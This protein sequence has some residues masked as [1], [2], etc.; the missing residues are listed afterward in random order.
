MNDSCV[1]SKFEFGI[2]KQRLS[3][4]Y[5]LSFATL[6]YIDSIWV[7]IEDEE[8]QKGLGDAVPLLGYGNESTRDIVQ[9]IYDFRQECIGKSIKVSFQKLYQQAHLHPFAVSAVASAI[10]FRHWGQNLS[11]L[12]PISLV[13]P[14]SSGPK[15][16]IIAG[17]I[18][19][20]FSKG[21]R[22]FKVKVGIN[23]EEDIRTGQYLL[24]NYADGCTFRF[25]ANQ[26]YNLEEAKAFCKQLEPFCGPGFQWLEQ[27]LPIKDWESMAILSSVTSLPLM[28]DES[29]Y[30]KE[31]ILRA[32]DIG[33]SAIKL[34]LFKHPG[35]DEL[36]RLAR[37][38]FSHGLKLTLGNGVSSDIGN[39]CEA[40]VVSMDSELYSPGLE[41]NGYNK[42]VANLAF[43][44]LQINNKGQLYWK[45]SQAIDFDRILSHLQ[46]ASKKT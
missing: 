37:L 1:I 18:E 38:A 14:I 7:Y 22:H 17:Q 42:L 46:R 8:G 27:P 43:P 5:R 26:A 45:N 13:Y 2:V 11:I 16:E 21:F 3:A 9:W 28:L 24:N 31:D 23:L 44:Q 19:D 4:P 30:Q 39:L 25:D 29:I 12:K 40:L 20:G 36:L 41:C 33:C 35:L 34:K 15:D 10:D 32:I 6:E